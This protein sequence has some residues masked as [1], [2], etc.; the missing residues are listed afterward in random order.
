MLETG[1][2]VDSRDHDR[3]TKSGT[4]RYPIRMVPADAT[5]AAIAAGSDPG[6]LWSCLGEMRSWLFSR[7]ASKIKLKSVMSLFLI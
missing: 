4:C 5:R 3:V 1:R 6:M 7:G 2:G